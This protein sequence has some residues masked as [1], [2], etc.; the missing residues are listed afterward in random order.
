MTAKSGFP[1][2][3]GVQFQAIPFGE[4]N[5]TKSTNQVSHS[6]EIVNAFDEQYRWMVFL[7]NLMRCR[8]L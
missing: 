6:F 5:K 1:N 8:I 3:T 4:A 7:L 2:Q